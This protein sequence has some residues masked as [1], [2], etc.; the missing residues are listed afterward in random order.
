MRGVRVD[1]GRVQAEQ[2]RAVLRS[3]GVY[4]IVAADARSPALVDAA[5]AA[6]VR[7]VQL[8]AKGAPDRRALELARDLAHRCGSAGALFIVNDRADL[9]V[10]AEADG[11]HVGDDDITVGDARAILGADR[12]VGASAHGGS[13]ARLLAAAG[14]DYLGSGSV[15]AT[16]SKADAAVRGL[17]VIREVRRSVGAGL[18]LYGI[19]GITAANARAVIDAGADGVAVI[20][21]IADAPEPRDAAAALVAAVER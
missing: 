18:P 2:R 8:R 5:L 14:V 12:L 16:A 17:D 1:N 13:G 3:G 6:G 15:F 19:G 11:V 20:A 4:F 9:A 21:A 10:L 7:I